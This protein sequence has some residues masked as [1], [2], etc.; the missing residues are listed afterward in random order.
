[1][2]RKTKLSEDVGVDICC[3]WAAVNSLLDGFQKICNEKKTMVICDEHHHAAVTAAWGIGAKGAF[4]NSKFVLILTGTPIRSDSENPVW[5]EYKDGQLRHPEDGQYLLSYGRSIELGYCR[6]IA[7]GRHEA[8]FNIYDTKGGPLLGSVSGK[9]AER[10]SEEIQGSAAAAMLQEETRFYSCAIT[11]I[12]KKDG[13]ADENS[14]QASML[15]EAITKLEERKLRLPLAG[16]LVIAPNLDTAEYMHELLEK[17]TG[18]KPLLVHHKIDDA[19]DLIKRFRVNFED[20]W[21]VS[22]DMIGEGVDIQRLRVLVYLPRA[23]TELKFRQAMGRVV[24]K[25]ED[26]A[27]DDSSAYCVMPAFEIFDKY[28]KRV[29]E[30]MPGKHLKQT[31]TTKKCPACETENKKDA[32]ECISK[33][34]DH[35]FPTSGPRYKKCGDE[36]CE[37]LNPVGAKSCQEC[38]KEF[39]TDFDISLSDVFRENV[40]SRGTMVSEE[41]AQAAESIGNAFYEYATKSDNPMIRE[42]SKKNPPETLMAFHKE[43]GEFINQFNKNNKDKR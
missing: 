26:I 4:K 11:P 38:G 12:R 18:K 24:R 31:K 41:D 40:I 15:R 35:Q 19:E 10:I 36:E 23:R 28:A 8:N 43:L 34:C 22:V 25:Y 14:Y 6:P 13:T 29:E 33:S 17:L 39:G 7:F 3:T 5:F 21:L 2:Q 42:W 27:D 30:E 37:A 9:G 20:D 32:K 16:G 1:M